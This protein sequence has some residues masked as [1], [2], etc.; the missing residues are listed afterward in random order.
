MGITLNKWERH[1]MYC[2][3]ELLIILVCRMVEFLQ[4]GSTDTLIV[5]SLLAPKCYLVEASQLGSSISFSW[6]QALW[7]QDVVY[8]KIQCNR[9]CR[10]EHNETWWW[11]KNRINRIFHLQRPSNKRPS[12]NFTWWP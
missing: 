9:S 11:W 5:L 8:N 2:S 7:R 4:T 1:W 12:E 10:S 3:L 6:F